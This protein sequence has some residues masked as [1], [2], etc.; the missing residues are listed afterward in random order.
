MPFFLHD[1]GF[2]EVEMNYGLFCTQSIE[3]TDESIVLVR[4]VAEDSHS[5]FAVV[6]V[7]SH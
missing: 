4:E 5:P 3:S 2:N 7:D 1:L 6:G